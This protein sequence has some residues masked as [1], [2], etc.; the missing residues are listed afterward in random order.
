MYS[1]IVLLSSSFI[2]ALDRAKLM[3]VGADLPMYSKNVTD[4]QS[5]FGLGEPS[6]DGQL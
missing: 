3:R 6:R 5:Q 2:Y 4:S 1:D